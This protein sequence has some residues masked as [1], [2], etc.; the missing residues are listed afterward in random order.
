LSGNPNYENID[1]FRIEAVDINFYL[2]DLTYNIP[3]PADTTPPVFENSKPAA[4]SIVQT[5]LTL[6]TDIDEAGTIYYVI[7]PNGATAPTSAEVKAGTGNGG[8]GQITSGNAAVNTGGFTNNFAVTGLTAGTAY[9][10][11]VVAQDDEGTPNLQT[12]P[13]K[14]D[15]TTTKYPLTITANVSQSKIYGATEPT[16]TYTI[17]GFVN[18]DNEASLDTPVSIARAVGEDVGNYTITP[19]AAADVNYNVSFVTAQFAINRRSIT[20]TSSNQEKIYGDVLDLDDRVFTV[21]DLDGDAVLPNGEVVTNVTINSATGVDSSTTSDVA[22]YTKEIVISGPV[23]GSDGTGDG[24]LESNYDIT[25]VSGDLKV[26]PR[27]IT[28][29][30]TQQEKI[31][32]DTYV[33][34]NDKT[35][36]TVTDLDGD[37]L[38]PNDEVIE[39][40]TMISR[41]MNDASTTSNAVT[42]VGDLEIT[43]FGTGSNNFDPANYTIDFSNLSD[44]VINRRAATINA[45]S[46]R[47]DYGDIY[48]LGNTA[49]TV[50]DRDGGAL[51]NSEVI[52]T[53]TLVS[54]NGIDASTDAD[55]VRYANNLSI[56]P[57]ATATPTLTG[58]ANFNQE[59][60][61]F[62]YGTADFTVDQRAI[63]L[64][65]SQQEKIYGNGL[66]LDNTA[67]TTRDR[68]GGSSLPNGEVVTNVTIVSAN[69]VDAST[70]SDVATYADEINI[71][72]PVV[73][74]AGT[75][76]GFLESNYDITYVSGDL[77]VNL[78]PITVTPTQ[79][80]KTYGDTYVLANDKTVFTVTDLDGDN[81]LPND[82]VIETVTM[83]SRGMN[84][85]STTSNA[86]TH[87]G[88]LEITEFGT[89]SNNFD[90]ANYTIDFSNLSDLVINRRAVTL[91][92]LQQE[93][94]Y[95][96]VHTLDTT[97]FSVTDLDNDALL[98]NG[99][100]IDTVT[101]VSADGIDAST[102]ANAVLYAD[103]IS[104]TPTSTNDQTIAGS[105]NFNQENYT[106]GYGTG[107]LTVNRRAAQIIASAQE[108]D[109]G[110]VHD[111]GDASFTVVDRDGGVLPNGETVNTVTL[112]SADG[113]DASTDANA[114]LYADNISVTP[115][116][117]NDQTIAG[118]ANFNQENY[119]FSYGT[120]DLTI[121][122]ANLT[123]TGITGGD[124]IY[125]DTIAA[126]ASGTATLNGLVSDDDVSLGGSPVFTFAS[127]NVGTEITI[128]TTGYTINGTDSGNYTL[129]QPTLSGDITAK[130]L[131]I[132]GITGSDKVYDGTTVASASGTPVLS[133]VLSNDD[134]VLGGTPVFTFESAELGTDIAITTTGFIITGSNNGNYTLTQPTLSADIVTTLGVDDITDVKLSLKLFP[135]P[136]VN[137]IKISGLSEK[138]NY[139]IY[140]LL[141]KEILRGKVLNEE[142]IFIQDLSNGTYFIKVENAKAIKFIKM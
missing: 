132:T 13:T 112:V 129:T 22:T 136:S 105:A 76:D 103:N 24:F 84:D 59:N 30:P 68:D 99:E 114:V 62:A 7:V 29:T 35:V 56:T 80:E 108:K 51:P 74:T 60:Y 113:I 32:G 38:L 57:T 86:V 69:G 50:I 121:N 31:Y 9:D 20:L 47:K 134:V 90:L 87:V 10:V 81:L 49:F 95:G 16:L 11:Y 135:N 100:T 1:E 54:A 3:L 109:Y 91:T 125:D 37:N 39:T 127:S 12:S 65:A 85:A 119:T 139:I 26:N 78:R 89:G 137:F 33:L 107:D 82:E 45:N 40:V 58:S 115:T 120:G 42:H 110:D 123:I 28:V 98:P 5:S 71:E 79:Q 117:T 88:D 70:T 17:T 116:S 19:S 41:G 138:A 15:V 128:N 2:D 133:G 126:T 6:E 4:S 104:V 73:G 131:T 27:P 106:F 53:V 101:L 97:T 14:V 48:D 55:A 124:K 111:L 93:K 21:I 44:L 122:L 52:E 36:F 64:T 72:S 34:A 67:F 43:E 118:S 66:N 92:A 25:Y 8:S 141:G 46:Q 23:A 96:D 142:N 140:N 83:I 130:E 61:T 63:T 18:G 94:D 75:G 77:K 102:D